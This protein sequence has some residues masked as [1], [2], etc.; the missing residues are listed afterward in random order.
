MN[1]VVKIHNSSSGEIH[2]VK[3]SDKDDTEWELDPIQMLGAVIP[4]IFDWLV[5][6]R[7]HDGATIILGLKP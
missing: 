3:W 5:E 2:E 7:H 6:H 4:L 1:E